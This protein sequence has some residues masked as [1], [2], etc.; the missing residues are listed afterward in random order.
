MLPTIFLL[1]YTLFIIVYQNMHIDVW[2]TTI[3]DQ[4]MQ[5]I[6]AWHAFTWLPWHIAM[7][8]YDNHLISI[9]VL[10]T[11]LQYYFLNW[12]PVRLQCAVITNIWLLPHIWWFFPQFNMGITGF[13]IQLRMNTHAYTRVYEMWGKVIIH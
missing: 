3:T 11:N 6:L 1:Q 10:W 5:C 12:L 9:M 13:H 7:P 2:I 8:F 4:F